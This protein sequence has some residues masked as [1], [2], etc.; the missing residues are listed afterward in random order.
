M[1]ITTRQLLACL[2][3][4]ILFLRQ[5]NDGLN[6]MSPL[7]TNEHF[8]HIRKELITTCFQLVSSILESGTF[9]WNQG[10]LVVHDLS[11]MGKH[12]VQ[13]TDTCILNRRH[14]LNSIAL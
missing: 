3:Y 12:P 7:S 9:V 8:L 6:Y 14:L 11:A 1:T 13:Y 10:H 4:R 5:S 2:R